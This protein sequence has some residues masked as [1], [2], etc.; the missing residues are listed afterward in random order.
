MAINIAQSDLTKLARALVNPD[1]EVRDQIFSSLTSFL[2]QVSTFSDIEMLKLWK[3][4]YYCMWLA[5]RSVVQVEIATFF[6]EL[7]DYIG[8]TKTIIQF[9][10]MFYRTILREWPMLDQHRLDKFYKLLRFMLRKTFQYLHERNFPPKLTTKLLNVLQNEVFTKTPNGVRFHLFDIFLPELYTATNGKLSND[11]MMLLLHSLAIVM[12]QTKDN[13]CYERISKK[14][15]NN[16]LTNYCTENKT[17]NDSSLA[18]KTV[19]ENVKLTAI[20]SMLFTIASDPS[21]LDTNRPNIY[22]LHKQYSIQTGIAFVVEEKKRKEHPVDQSSKTEKGAIT[23]PGVNDNSND[24]DDYRNGI[25]KRKKKYVENSEE[26][27]KDESKVEKHIDSE[28]NN[29]NRGNNGHKRNGKMNQNGNQNHDE[30][31]T[32]E[33]EIHVNMEEK[34][35]KEKDSSLKIRQD[36]NNL[37]DSSSISKKDKKINIL[38][39]IVYTNQKFI[40]SYR[41]KQGI[42]G[43]VYKQVNFPILYF[44]L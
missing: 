31:V 1:K 39:E 25:P 12:S 3:A 6:S 11:K 35:E 38:K 13:A 5:D 26:S 14:I 30:L 34:K 9:Y 20:Q 7:V 28:V 37:V 10:K 2:S 43:Y 40:P 41:F 24:D 29:I 33:F 17:T 23:S 4:L 21:T 8:N 32:K 22:S 19:F 36:T 18:S 27:V 16:Y 42:P 44:N 15:F